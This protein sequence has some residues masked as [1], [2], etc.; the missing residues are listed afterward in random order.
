MEFLKTVTG[1]VVSGLVAL[2]VIAAAISWWQ[3]EPQTRQMLV[4]GTGKIVGWVLVILVL[5]WAT[6]FVSTGVAKYDSNLAGILLVISYTVL[7]VLLL[8]WLFDWSIHGAAAWTFL[9]V[10]GLF[11]GA[12]NLF[13]CDWIAEKLG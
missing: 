3:M 1:K 4:S 10:G 2:G 13:T 8:A 6:F 11:A 5:P 12:Y 9:I 7:E